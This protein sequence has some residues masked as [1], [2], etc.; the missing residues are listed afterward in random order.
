MLK[1]A[2]RRCIKLL[3]PVSSFKTRSIGTYGTFPIKVFPTYAKLMATSN[4]GVQNYLQASYKSI[5][6]DRGVCSESRENN[7]DGL[8]VRMDRQVLNFNEE[9]NFKTEKSTRAGRFIL[10]SAVFIASLQMMIC[11]T[12]TFSLQATSKLTLGFPEIN[13]DLFWILSLCM[14]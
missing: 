14:L 10:V 6:E 8:L 9:F 7:F 5:Q 12:G 11:D 3:Q 13:S 2:L 4:G 1:G